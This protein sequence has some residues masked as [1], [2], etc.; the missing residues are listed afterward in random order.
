MSRTVGISLNRDEKIQ[1]VK[2]WDVSE[3]EIAPLL[4]R[5][6]LDPEI[7]LKKIDPIKFNQKLKEIEPQNVVEEVPLSEIKDHVKTMSTSDLKKAL[8]ER[9]KRTVEANVVDQKGLYTELNLENYTKKFFQ[10]WNRSLDKIPEYLMRVSI[11][12]KEEV[13]VQEL[14]NRLVI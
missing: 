3:S 8:Q 2:I 11:M 12:A 9:A 4:K 1:A 6:L 13:I 14:S 5:I 10:N 7:V